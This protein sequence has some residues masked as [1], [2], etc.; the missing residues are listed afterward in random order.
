MQGIVLLLS[1]G[2]MLV[3]MLEVVVSALA[4]GPLCLHTSIWLSPFLIFKD[5]HFVLSAV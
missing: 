5:E 3:D 4:L 2:V 1:A